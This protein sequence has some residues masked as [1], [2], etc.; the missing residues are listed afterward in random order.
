VAQVVGLEFKP[1]Y[2]EKKRKRKYKLKSQ[3]DTTE[4]IAEW[5]KLERIVIPSISKTT[6]QL[7]LTYTAGR[8]SKMIHLLFKAVDNFL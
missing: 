3:K 2:C 8:G 1:Q 7:G 5:L 4:H 6:Q